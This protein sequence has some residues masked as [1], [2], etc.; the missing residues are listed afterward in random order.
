MHTVGHGAAEYVQDFTATLKA[1]SGQLLTDH[2]S[3]D[4]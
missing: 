3:H 4:L 1:R 2:V